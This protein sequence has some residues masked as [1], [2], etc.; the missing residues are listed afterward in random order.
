M[1]LGPRSSSPRLAP[2]SWKGTSTFFDLGPVVAEAA[3]SLGKEGAYWRDDSLSA[4]E[5]I[6][7]KRPSAWAV[8]AR[9]PANLLPLEASGPWTPLSSQRRPTGGPWLWTDRTSSPLAAMRGWTGGVR[10][11]APSSPHQ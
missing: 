5:A 4:V 7:G 8:V 10:A 6:T 3:A 1:T 11:L 9:D 2:S